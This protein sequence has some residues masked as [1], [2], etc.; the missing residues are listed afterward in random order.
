MDYISQ[1]V[2]SAQRKLKGKHHA[3]GWVLPKQRTSFAPE[4]TWTNADLD[5]TPPERQL[6]TSVSVVGYWLSGIVS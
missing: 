3:S 6:W 2:G 5:V 4:G 1:R